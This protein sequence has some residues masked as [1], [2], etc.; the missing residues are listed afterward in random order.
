[1]ASSAS[2]LPTASTSPQYSE[3]GKPSVFERPTLGRVVHLGELFD[4]RSNQFLGVQLYEKEGIKNNVAITDMK[5]TELTLSLSNSIK[6]KSNILDIN[7][8]LC[9]D[10]LGGLVKASGSA[11]YLKDP[12]SNSY[13]RSW[14]MALKMQTE[15]HCLLFAEDELDNKVVDVVK[16]SY[17]S[18]GLTTHFV[19]AVIYGGNIVIGMTERSSN[20]TKKENIKGNLQLELDQLKGAVSLTGDAEADIKGKFMCLDNMFDLVAYGDIE[21]AKIPF[22]A[23]DVLDIIPHAAD[24]IRGY[25]HGGN[26]GAAGANNNV[27]SNTEVNYGIKGVPVSVTLQPIPAKLRKDAKIDLDVFRLKQLVINEA[28]SIFGRLDDLHNRF[29]TLVGGTTTYREFIPKLAD[30]AQAST[31]AFDEEYLRHLQSLGQ[32]LRDIQHGDEKKTEVNNFEL[33]SYPKAKKLYT[34]HTTVT[35]ITS[36]LPHEIPL[37]CLE[38]SFKDFQNLVHDISRVPGGVKDEDGNELPSRLSTIDDVCRAPRHQSIIPLFLMTPSLDHHGANLAV[39]RFLALLH[40]RKTFHPRYLVYLEDT[41]DEGILPH[42]DFLNLGGPAYFLGN[43]DANGDLT[44]TRNEEDKPDA[45][46]VQVPIQVPIQA[47][48]QDPLEGPSEGHIKRIVYHHEMNTLSV[49]LA[50]VDDTKSFSVVF[51]F[52]SRPNTGWFAKLGC[53]KTWLSL[54]H[55][56]VWKQYGEYWADDISLGTAGRQ[57]GQHAMTFIQDAHHQEA[58]VYMSSGLVDSSQLVMRPHDPGYKRVSTGQLQI[59]FSLKL[60]SGHSNS[61]RPYIVT[62]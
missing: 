28:L 12:K 39:V 4:E 8:S 31:N 44:W 3:K 1:M 46:S 45:D 42:E 10:V 21:L 11:S 60:S 33:T 48:S 20:S 55:F 47:P 15:E 54:S 5:Y 34:I 29:T 2:S 56:N 37:V 9:L 17:I 30:R 7:P 13:A 51:V 52:S 26:G 41:S 32:F 27:A 36:L 50:N 61:W 19:S 59:Y 43:V 24:L 49:P 53:S 14:A 62:M 6:D 22:N 18:A 57:E 23:K 25:P 58:L 38:K 40:S 35:D 16:E